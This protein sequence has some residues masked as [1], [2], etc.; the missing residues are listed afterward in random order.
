VFQP[1]GM[2]TD[3]GYIAR[4]MG[5]EVVEQDGVPY[6]SAVSANE[7]AARIMVNADD[8]WWRK[9][10]GVAHQLGHL[11]HDGPRANFRDVDYDGTSPDEV[12]ANRFAAELMMPA[13]KVAPLV[14]RFGAKVIAA[15]FQVSTQAM[16]IR[17]EELIRRHYR[18]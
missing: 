8:P 18:P 3:V 13:D 11:L 9:R 6:A 2:V 5:V 10:F 4:R 14:G 7:T 12:R 17:I 16:Q 1:V 15:L